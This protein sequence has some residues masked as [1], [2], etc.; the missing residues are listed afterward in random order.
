MT[1]II[2]IEIQRKMTVVIK[3][4]FLMDKIDE[5]WSDLRLYSYKRNI[6]SRNLQ[7][8]SSTPL[9]VVVAPHP[10]PPLLKERGFREEVV[11]L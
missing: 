1:R 9:P 10:L 11:G 8:I 6:I 5:D 7:G 4:A 2:A 3:N